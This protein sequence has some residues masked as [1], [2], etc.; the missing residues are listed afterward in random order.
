MTLVLHG[1]FADETACF[2][3]GDIEIADEDV[4]HQPIAQPGQDC[5]CLAVTDGPLKFRAI[6]PRLAQPFLRI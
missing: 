2:Q 3:R 4:E 1:A 5:I 6:L